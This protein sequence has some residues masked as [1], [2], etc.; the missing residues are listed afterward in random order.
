MKLSQIFKSQNSYY[1]WLLNIAKII[2][3][4][5]FAIVILANFSPFFDSV[6]NSY[7][8][9]LQA[10]RIAEGDSWTASNSL[11]EE[12]GSWEFVPASWKK[13]IHDTAIPKHSPGL[14]IIGSIF[15]SIGGLS[16]L[17]Y[18]GPIFAILLLIASDRIAT[19]L[20]NKYV[21]FFTL[22]FL[23][24]NG[25]VFTIGQDLLTDNIFALLTITGFFCLVK[26]IFEKKNNY[27][28]YASLLFSFSSFVRI[29]GIFYF[30]IEI[31]I[32]SLFL[33]FNT[34]KT[35]KILIYFNSKIIQNKKNFSYKDISKMALFVIGPWLI[36][37]LFF[38]IFNTYHF[39]EPSITYYTIPDDPVLK[40][41]SGSIFSILELK[42]E[43][44]EILKSFSNY[45]LPYPIYRI[46]LLDF[47]SIIQE[48]DDPLT[49]TS[50]QSL[51]G[52]VGQ[53]NLGILTFLILIVA[54]GISFY[55]KKYRIVT[56]TFCIIIA[57]MLLFW[58]A[59][60]IA[61]SIT[62]AIAG[63]YVVPVFPLI[64]MIMGFVIVETLRIRKFEKKRKINFSIKI[65]K[66]ILICF[67]FMFFIIALIN[68]A[69]MQLIIND[70]FKLNNPIDFLS[71]YPLDH[72]GLD[73]NSILVGGDGDKAVDYGFI[74][75]LPFAELNFLRDGG[76]SDSQ[77]NRDSI[78]TLKDLTKSEMNLILLKEVR[79]KG[80]FL[81]R[82]ELIINH[83]FILKDISPSFCKMSLIDEQIEYK[84]TLE[85][86]DSIC[87][88][89]KN[90]ND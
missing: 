33:I 22:L 63:R 61:Y 88:G 51:K 41:G 86:S 80:E 48:R 76:Y 25:Y 8:H 2:I 49:T 11:L 18:L 55:I 20:F 67:I 43:H 77:V 68:S 74:P 34:N 13:T 35:Q 23:A 75:L 4:V 26:F 45:V 65:L 78:K 14:A 73:P 42:N 1:D 85:L 57:S 58:T 31:I 79:N 64:S 36:F 83:G 21:G 82:K 84:N 71:M 40:T 24:T 69:P 30:P 89:N 19:K 54:M 12:T 53:N 38:I 29:N 27:L 62:P 56:S 9:G 15:Y 52:L 16:A 46:E 81:F 59:N 37:I 50:L 44:G 6:P 72:E 87:Y 28:L 3:I 70:E 10:I 39:G 90:S 60:Q 32:V 47:D 17:F 66:I 7:L 5:F